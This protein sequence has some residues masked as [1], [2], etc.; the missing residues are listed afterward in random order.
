MRKGARGEGG[1]PCVP[2][3][4][5][6]PCLCLRRP[7]SAPRLATRTQVS[8]APQLFAPHFSPIRHPHSPPHRHSRPPLCFCNTNQPGSN[9]HTVRHTRTG[10][11]VGRIRA[12]AHTLYISLSLTRNNKARSSRSISQSLLGLERHRQ[13]VDAVALVGGRGEALALEDVAQV[14][15]AVAAGDLDA[16]HPERP[17]LVAV[18]GAGEVVVVCGPAAARVELGAA[19]VVVGLVSCFGL[20]CL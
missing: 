6:P 4:S 20:V 14:A 12:G 13:R 16:N 1:G 11:H 8:L 15:P 10:Q 7:T 17:V 9:L 3:F 19:P 5:F 2:S 18:D